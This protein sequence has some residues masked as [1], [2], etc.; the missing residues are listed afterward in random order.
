M[1]FFLNNPLQRLAFTRQCKQQMESPAARG[2]LA[3]K[4]VSM[5]GDNVWTD[6]EFF[7]RLDVF[8]KAKGWSLYQLCNETSVSHQTLYSLRKRSGSPNLQTIC[9]ICDALDITVSD[10][11]NDNLALSPESV[12][13]ARQVNALSETDR[14]MVAWFVNRLHG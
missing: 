14:Q 1:Q 4:E 11:F 8:L 12:V 2:S 13:I 3:L 6:I 7:E 5:E 9:S 10:F